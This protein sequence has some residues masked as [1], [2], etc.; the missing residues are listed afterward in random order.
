MSTFFERYERGEH[1]QVWNE[2][3]E[4]G[5]AVR[6][7]PLFSDALAV[8]RETMRRARA[9]IEMLIPRLVAVGYQFGYGWVQP[10][11]RERLIRPYRANYDL[12]SGC[13]NVHGVLVQPSIPDHFMDE[14]RI[15]YEERLEMA[16]Q[17]PSLFTPA[18]DAE[19]RIAQ[20]DHQIA[21]LSPSPSPMRQHLSE[22]QAELRAKP[23]PQA[24]LSELEALLGTVPLS[25]R[26]WYEVVGGVNFVGDHPGWRALLPEAVPDMPVH[27]LDYLNP[28]HVLNP[29][30][31]FPLDEAR[32]AQCRIGARPSQQ[33]NYF[34]LA[35]DEYGKYLDGT[36]DYYEILVPNTAMDAP[37][38]YYKQMFTDYLRDCFRWGGFPGWAKLE[39]RPEE[40]LA[41][42]TR[43]LLPL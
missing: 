21:A 14:Q 16:R 32:L 24:L 9:N 35:E 6:D 25:V 17:W 18:T 3:V 43:G 23:T 40:D 36:R 8:A 30:F 12:S 4:M 2:L 38:V 37:F 26:A 10:Y 41:F 19:E 7:E 34:I 11:M 28:M 42:L 33:G 5:P 31:L 29:L 22:M 39:K 27:P 1:E 15:D 20:L 13:R